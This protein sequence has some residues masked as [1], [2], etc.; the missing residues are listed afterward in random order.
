MT[1]AAQSMEGSMSKDMINWQL[2]IPLV[3][4]SIVAISGWIVGH[5]LN[6]ERDLQNKRVELRIKYLLEAYR[7][8]EA[9]VETEVSRE[10]LKILESAISD[11]QLLGSPDQVDKILAWSS[12]F[13]KAGTQKDVN[14]QDVLEDLRSSLRK[15]LGLP[16]IDK[17]IRHVKFTLA[18]DV[19]EKPAPE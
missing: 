14:L 15:D 9:S 17:K 11:V 12:Q 10:N 16:K 3:V 1:V 6:A 18:S 8:L 5:R 7:N 19:K 2:L 13:T 4:T